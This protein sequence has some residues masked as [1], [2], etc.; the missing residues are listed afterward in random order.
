MA[1][2]QKTINI[3]ANTLQ[4]NAVESVLKINKGVIHK[5]EVQFPSGC[6]GLVH[7]QILRNRTQIAPLNL[8]ENIASD[9]KIISW[10]EFIEF[11]TNPT[12][13]V[14]RSWNEDDTY[15][16]QITIYVHM[17]PKFVLVPSASTEGILRT[18]N[19]VFNE[20]Q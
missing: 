3:S 12:E 15:S 13:L 5:I 11:N 20:N 17:L 7:C 4:T 9:G 6:A 16:H 18:L 19:N 1:L 2:Y 10:R 8:D 14:I